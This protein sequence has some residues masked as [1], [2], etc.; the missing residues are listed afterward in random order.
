[1]MNEKINAATLFSQGKSIFSRTVKDSVANLAPPKSPRIVNKAD[2]LYIGDSDSVSSKSSKSLT[3]IVG[4]RILTPRDKWNEI[5]DFKLGDVSNA[6]TNANAD[7]G[8]NIE[9]QQV[10][11]VLPKVT[12]LPATATDQEALHATVIIEESDLIIMNDSLVS[13]HYL[14]QETKT[15]PSRTAK[16]K[17]SLLNGNAVLRKGAIFT[18]NKG[19][20]S[21][22]DI[23]NLSSPHSSPRNELESSSGIP[24]I[25]ISSSNEGTRP[26]SA[27]KKVRSGSHSE[28]Y[29]FAGWG[30][31]AMKDFVDHLIPD[32]A[33]SETLSASPPST[34][35]SKSSSYGGGYRSNLKGKLSKKPALS[36]KTGDNDGQ[37]GDVPATSPRLKSATA[38]RHAHA[39]LY[40]NKANKNVR[41]SSK[42]DQ[43][44]SVAK[45]LQKKG[46]EIE[47]ERLSFAAAEEAAAA[48][49]EEVPSKEEA[50]VPEVIAAPQRFI[51]K[52]ILPSHPISPPPQRDAP[53]VPSS[54]QEI[55]VS[56]D[57][58][59]SMQK[60][61]RNYTQIRDLH[62]PSGLDRLIQVEEQKRINIKS[63]SCRSVND[64]MKK[65]GDVV[66]SPPPS[67]M[68]RKSIIMEERANAEK[69]EKKKLAFD[70][71]VAVC[72][73]PLPSI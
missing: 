70:D 55:V 12:V 62:S 20:K 51:R 29:S 68:A 15:P 7:H 48:V 54:S 59:V 21:Q 52:K 61:I 14:P 32:P 60:Q 64:F 3:G 46:L 47:E 45:D 13:A 19:S 37:D 66:V 5:K 67:A 49:V 28:G 10:K 63:T 25:A 24:K 1:M 16:P 38:Y 30:G 6:N 23:Q 58:I 26:L 9:V 36:S 53:A 71:E 65:A 57:M 8:T 18:M 39:L 69:K 33:N 41:A 17:S 73:A 35:E 4:E 72:V 43:F 31:T 40:M 22:L 11:A 44:L 42:I 56:Q 2:I 27:S 34:S 50:C